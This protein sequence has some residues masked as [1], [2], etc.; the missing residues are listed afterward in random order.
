M[1]QLQNLIMI[2]KGGSGSNCKP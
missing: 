1:T 2:A